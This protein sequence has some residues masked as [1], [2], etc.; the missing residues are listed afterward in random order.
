MKLLT[1]VFFLACCILGINLNAVAEEHETPPNLADMW[2]VH[3][4][5][6]MGPA[7][8]AAFKEHL[9]F[10]QEQGDPREWKTYTVEA[11][12]DMDTYSIRSCCHHWAD[13]D[14]YDAW[15]GEAEVGAHFNANVDQY[16]A[17]YEHFFSAI[18]FENSNW[19]EDV[20]DVNF[21]GVTS[22]K[23]KPG[24]EGGMEA[25]KAKMSSLAKE[26]GWPRNW[27]WGS[28]IVGPP[29]LTIASPFSDFAGMEAPE[30]NFLEFLTE[31]MGSQEE[32][33]ELLSSFSTSAKG[34][35][36]TIYR[37]RE[38]LSSPSDEE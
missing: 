21:V 34:S 5:A 2:V 30:Q 24:A 1:K 18:D 14:A 11:G 31:H 20:T 3:V 6:N 36:Y 26:H 33:D 25:A 27:A 19:S 15:S 22:W 13:F 7:F 8:E 32:A 29:L 23:I 10:R 35:S 38:D 9:A 37:Y 17:S 16:V 28:S 12:G 4:K